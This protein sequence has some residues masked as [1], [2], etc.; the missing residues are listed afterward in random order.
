MFKALKSFSGK[1][2]M[3]KGQVKDIKDEAII[4]DLL[5]AGYIEEIKEEISTI[6]NEVE[7]VE[8]EIKEQVEEITEVE[9]PKK[10]TTRK[11]K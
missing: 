6:K 1:L 4:K 8:N 2:S 7:K 5:N 10:T 3:A 9:K 11:K